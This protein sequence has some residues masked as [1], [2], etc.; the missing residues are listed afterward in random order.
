M[1]HPVDIAVGGRIR[2]LRIGNGLSQ[3]EL[4]RL[5]GVS[6]QQVQKYEKGSNRLGASRIVQISEALC[7]PVAT[8]FDGIDTTKAAQKHKGLSV[9]AA[10]IA[11]EWSEIE[12]EDLQIAAKNLIRAMR[13]SSTQKL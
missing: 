9:E 4:G 1:P 2:T 12:N 6:F 10:K 7:V 3:E 8:I 11:R 13:H 5:I